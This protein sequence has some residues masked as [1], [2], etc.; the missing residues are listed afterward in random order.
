MIP[1]VALNYSHYER[2]EYNTYPLVL[3]KAT[4]LFW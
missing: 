4:V 1:H 2:Y 3:C